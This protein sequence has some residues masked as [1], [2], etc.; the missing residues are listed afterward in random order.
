MT[1][2]GGGLFSRIEALV[3]DAWT[4]AALAA[5]VSAELSGEGLGEEHGALLGA[6][7]FAERTD[8]GWRLLPEHREA[9][10][11]RSGAGA[12]PGRLARMLRLAADAAEGVPEQV[13]DGDEVLLA[14][15]RVSGE[16]VVRLLDLAARHDPGLRGLAEHPGPRFLDIGTGV[17]GVAAALA[18]RFPHGQ[19]VGLDTDPRMVR[20]SERHLEARGAAGHRTGHEAAGHGTADPAEARP[21]NA[22]DTPDKVGDTTETAVPDMADRVE[23]RLA[24]AADLAEEACYDLVW[25]PLSVLSPEAAAAALPRAA[26]ALRP[27]GRLLAATALR[28]APEGVRDGVIAWRM[29]LRGVTPWPPGEV[30]TRLEGVGLTAK[31]IPT[32]PTSV[33]LVVAHLP[34]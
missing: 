17:G 8:R 31:E 28:E 22:A 27:G 5:A 24:D 15:G 14:E 30:V 19:A 34:E 25:L 2:S 11:A 18:E 29:S 33:A 26:R 6:A 7:G 21:A 13:E 23:I 32:A 1:T 9:L 16:R 20:L 4:L 12:V 3:G 10:R